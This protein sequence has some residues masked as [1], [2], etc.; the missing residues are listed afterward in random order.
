MISC[1][2]FAWPDEGGKV[3]P[4]D[5]MTLFETFANA[6]YV[7][8]NHVR[9]EVALMSDVTALDINRRHNKCRL[10]TSRRR[11][12]RTSTNGQYVSSAT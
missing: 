4:S 7:C 2:E 1:N 9:E 3:L 12:A 5:W 10:H 11:N 6:C 8:R